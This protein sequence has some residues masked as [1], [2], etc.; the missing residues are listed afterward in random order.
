MEH[1]H[2]FRKINENQDGILEICRECKFRLTTKKDS[3][4]QRIDNRRYSNAHKRD[5]LQPNG[6]NGKQFERYY[7]EAPKDLRYK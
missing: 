5:L 1:L 3:K 2:D 4:T 7:G 6:R